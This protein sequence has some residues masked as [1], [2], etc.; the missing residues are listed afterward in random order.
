M[1]CSLSRTQSRSLTM[2]FC[3]H[4]ADEDTLNITSVSSVAF[5]Q[6]MSNLLSCTSYRTFIKPMICPLISGNGLRGNRKLIRHTPILWSVTSNVCFHSLRPFMFSCAGVPVSMHSVSKK[7]S[8]KAPMLLTQDVNYQVKIC[9]AIF[10]TNILASRQ[11]SRNISIIRV[12]RSR[13]RLPSSH[14][15]CFK[16]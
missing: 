3:K 12:G 16:V 1:A 8:K 14:T 13:S 4:S 6:V 15:R 7:K 2:P 11:E 9:R 5:K 10:K